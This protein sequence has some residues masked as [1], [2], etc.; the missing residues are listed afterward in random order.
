MI[1][2]TSPRVAA[3]FGLNIFTLGKLATIPARVAIATAFLAYSG[4]L[5]ASL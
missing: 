3:T 5:A 2:A 1:A 4:I